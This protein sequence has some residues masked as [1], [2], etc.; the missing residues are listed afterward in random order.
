MVIRS[1]AQTKPFPRRNNTICKR[2]VSQKNKQKNQGC[3]SLLGKR[4]AQHVGVTVHFSSTMIGCHGFDSIEHAKSTTE[5]EKVV[6][7]GRL[8]VGIEETR[9][10]VVEGWRRTGGNGEKER[11]QRWEV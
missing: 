8:A 3:Y 11:R 5:T 7:P 2:R 9:S 4:L 1:P 6:G 10:R